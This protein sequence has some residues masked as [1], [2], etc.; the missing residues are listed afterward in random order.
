MASLVTAKDRAKTVSR[1]KDVPWFQSK[2]GSSLTLTGRRLLEQ[3]SGIAPSDV[4]AHI[5]R[6]VSLVTP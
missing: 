6:I 4:E 5:Y 3:Y 1:S 2:I